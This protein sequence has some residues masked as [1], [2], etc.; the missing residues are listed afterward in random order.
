LGVIPAKSLVGGE[1]TSGW[2]ERVGLPRTLASPSKKAAVSAVIDSNSL[3]QARSI[4]AEAFRNV[5]TSVLFS[6]QNGTSPRVL[7]VTSANP[8]EGKTT[9]TANLAVAL[10]EIKLK[11]L[12]V[13]ADL[14]KPRMHEL[15]GLKNEQGLS[16]VLNADGLTMEDVSTLIQA[17]KTR[18]VH[19]LPSGPATH[20]AANLLH[21]PQ[22]EQILTELKNQFDMIL[23]DTPPAMQLPDS[24]IVGRLADAVILVTQAGRTTRDAAIAVA[25]RFAEDRTHLLGAIL[26]DWK[27]THRGQLARYNDHYAYDI[28]KPNQA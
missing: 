27:P 5:L 14:R 1:K 22:L 8:G 4:L 13:D 2:I 15:F 17:T 7:V 9:I 12:I 20:A 28:A 16:S 6:G 11:V 23:I 3:P 26:N 19:L 24:R 10:A 25:G 18:G 21:S